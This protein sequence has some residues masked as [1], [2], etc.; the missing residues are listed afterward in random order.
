MNSSY[1][2]KNLTFG[3]V[4]LTFFAGA[5]KKSKD[6]EDDS[7]K[8]VES[9][10]KQTA[11]T[12]RT[13][14]TNDSLFLYAKQIY[15]WNDVLPGYDTFNPRQYASDYNKELFTITQFKINPSTGKPFEYVAPEPGFLDETKYSYIQDITQN[16]P[17]TTASV[18]QAKNSVDLEGFGNDIGIRP[19]SYLN[20]DNYNGPF[21]LYVTAVYPNSPADKAGVKRGWL[22]KTINGTAVGTSY[23][24]QQSFLNSS[25]SESSVALTGTKYSEGVAGESFSVTLKSASYTSSPIYASKVITAGAKKI[26]YLALARFSSES[27]AITVLDNAFTTFSSQGVTDLVVDLRYNGG[28]YVSTA[29]HL[30]NLIAPST[31]T[32]TMFIEYYNTM[33]QTGKSVILKNQPRKD[34][35]DKIVGTYDDYDYSPAGN[36]ATFTKAGA[37][38]SVKNIVFL[39]SSSTAS[40]SELVINSL[41]PHM[42][43]KLVGDTTYGKPVGFFPVR[44][45]NRYD[46]YLAS[47]ETKNSAGQGG[48]YTGMVP[49]VNE[50]LASS[51]FF[52]DPRYNF[53]EVKEKYLAKALSLLAPGITATGS[54]KSAVMSIGGRTVP[55]SQIEKIKPL[56]GTDGFNGMIEDRRK[57]K[58]K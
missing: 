41:K 10:L 33:M 39:V 13:Q 16:N 36:T 55:S 56:N 18:P 14:L 43:V 29:E 12:D 19:I 21:S 53:G 35:N 34:D 26:G 25:L 57:L 4:I 51:D 37:L 6:A 44:L 38:N 24:A 3:I 54:T 49:D 28:G 46:V 23:T 7:T 20:T 22:I 5:C 30:V 15:Y 45:E 52:D 17:Q 8:V 42:T 31:A 58:I 27:N 40:A 2:V 11:T 50:N 1:L 48:Y 32:G 9:N 47:F